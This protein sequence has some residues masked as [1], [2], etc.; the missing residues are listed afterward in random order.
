MAQLP[1]FPATRTTSS[2]PYQYSG[3]YASSDQPF[4]CSHCARAFSKEHNFRKHILSPSCF[5]NRPAGAPRFLCVK[6]PTGTK[7]FASKQALRGHER[8]YHLAGAVLSSPCGLCPEFFPTAAAVK[9]HRAKKHVLHS[10]FRLV[11]SAHRHSC[12]LWRCFLPRAEMHLHA[13][14]EWGYEQIMS[15]LETV[16]VEFSCFKVSE[17]VAFCGKKK[18][19][20]AV[21]SKQ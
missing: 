21:E 3:Q 9:R 12:Q 15:Q 13:A 7:S 18:K 2:Q 14:L 10:E 20:R 19:I 4:Y 8:L 17:E 1:I 5:G 11:Q 16:A 6:C